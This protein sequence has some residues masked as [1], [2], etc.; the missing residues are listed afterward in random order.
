MNIIQNPTLHDVMA[1]L[2]PNGNEA[3]VIEIMNQ[4]SDI[5]DGMV[6]TEANSITSH[7]TTVRS[8]LPDATW[9]KLYQGVQPSKST[10]DSVDEPICML[11][12]LSLVDSK[13]LNL[14]SSDKARWRLSE[15][16]PFIQSLRRKVQECLFS[17][18]VISDG[19]VGFAQRFNSLSAEN[20][21]NIVNAGGT[22][23]TNTSIWL[24]L[25]SEQTATMI[26]PRNSQAGISAKDMGE[27]LV[28]DGKG[29][30]AKFKA[31]STMYEWDIGL[32]VRDWRYV[33]RICNIDTG[34]LAK[35]GD[36]AP[37]LIELLSRAC[38]RIEDFN[39][40]RPVIYMNRNTAEALDLQHRRDPQSSTL[41][42]ANTEGK[43][44]TTFRKIPIK[45]VDEITNT[46]KEVQ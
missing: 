28:D 18:S 13:L 33:S 34:K 16:V 8:G 31:Q 36:D 46:E 43:V 37:N 26:Y 24:V 17:D 25:W 30:G 12:A 10:V 11:S 3:K 5:F 7:R 38:R 6:F 23:N 35:G 1:R 2:D 39:I 22:G 4:T 44:V 15:E 41:D 40:G 27:S 42:Y 20:S 19:F 32:A 9:R 29:T 21:R 14:Y 45:V